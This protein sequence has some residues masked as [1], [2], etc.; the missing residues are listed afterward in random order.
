METDTRITKRLSL[1]FPNLRSIHTG[2]DLC[3]FEQAVFALSPV[4][5]LESIDAVTLAI[6][7]RNAAPIAGYIPVS[8]GVGTGKNKSKANAAG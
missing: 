5:F 2:L 4:R 1:A 6:L 7:F 3:T 8:T